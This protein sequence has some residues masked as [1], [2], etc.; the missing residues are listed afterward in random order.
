MMIFAHRRSKVLK[1]LRLYEDLCSHA[2]QNIENLKVISG[3]LQQST[4]PCSVALKMLDMTL[5]PPRDELGQQM[6]KNNSK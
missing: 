2:V 1:I 5:A 6:A 4:F 3:L